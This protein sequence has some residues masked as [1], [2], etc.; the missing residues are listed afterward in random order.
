MRTNLRSFASP[1]AI[2]VA[3]ANAAS[4]IDDQ[5]WSSLVPRVADSQEYF[6]APGGKATNAGTRESPW[7]IASAL[8]GR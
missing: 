5:Q 2:L 4:A 6:A 8:G 7:D 3:L 1:V